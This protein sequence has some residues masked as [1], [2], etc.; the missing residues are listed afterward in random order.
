MGSSSRLRGNDVDHSCFNEC[1]L[2]CAEEVMLKEASLNFWISLLSP[3]STSGLH[4]QMPRTVILLHT[5]FSVC[6]VCVRVCECVQHFCCLQLVLLQ[7]SQKYIFH[8]FIQRIT[9]LFYLMSTKSKS[10]QNSVQEKI[11][12]YDSCLKH[13]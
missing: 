8:F 3:V 1:A 7:R 2:V 9:I 13:N 6:V 12:C 4:T 10:T 5:K 11:N